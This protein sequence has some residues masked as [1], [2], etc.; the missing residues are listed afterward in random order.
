[1]PA[2]RAVGC[3]N[4]PQVYCTTSFGRPPEFFISPMIDHSLRSR[5]SSAVTEAVRPIPAVLAGWEGGSAAFGLV[6]AFSDIDLG[7]MV[8]DDVPLERLYEVAEMALET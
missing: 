5:I 3:E 8:A 2:D 7:Y 1:M 4:A 6:D